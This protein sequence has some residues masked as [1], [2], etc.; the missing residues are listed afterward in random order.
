M[1]TVP[2]EFN[3]LF[4]SQVLNHEVPYFPS[5]FRHTLSQVGKPYF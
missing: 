5:L 4:A 1:G 3:R 2:G